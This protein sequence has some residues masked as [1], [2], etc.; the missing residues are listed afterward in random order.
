M[1]LFGE[2]WGP[3]HAGERLGERAFLTQHIGLEMSAGTAAAP[4]ILGVFCF[5]GKRG[6]SQ[7]AYAR[8]CSST[9]LVCAWAGRGGTPVQCISHTTKG[10]YASPSITACTASKGGGHRISPLQHN[11]EYWWYC[12]SFAAKTTEKEHQDEQGQQVGLTLALPSVRPG[13][14]QTAEAAA[15]RRDVVCLSKPWL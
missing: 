4:V 7:S 1:L 2:W 5:S 13:G 15:G 14:P 6:G 11:T 10:E 3:A 9:M 12:I 8:S